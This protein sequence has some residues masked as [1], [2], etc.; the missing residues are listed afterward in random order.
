MLYR[1]VEFDKIITEQ[2][3]ITGVANTQGVCRITANKTR[4]DNTSESRQTSF[5]GASEE[6]L[7]NI[8][9]LKRPWFIAS[10]SVG[11]YPETD[12]YRDLPVRG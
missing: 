7:M 10:F 6:M 5:G 9:G 8:L 1:R 3:G 4:I 2:G 12:D 11:M